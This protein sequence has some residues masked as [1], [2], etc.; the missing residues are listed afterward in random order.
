[1]VTVTPAENTVVD[2]AA[3][4]SNRLLTVAGAEKHRLLTV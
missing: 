1:L 2:G 3:R 4:R